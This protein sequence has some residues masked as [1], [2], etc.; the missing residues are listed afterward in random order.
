MQEVINNFWRHHITTSNTEFLKALAASATEMPAT[1]AERA[2]YAAAEQRAALVPATKIPKLNT[3]S[4]AFEPVM[5]KSA[6]FRAGTGARESFL[7]YK[8]IKTHGAHRVE[9]KGEE[10]RQDDLRVL[11]MLLKLNAGQQ[12]GEAKDFQEIGA[13]A[14][15][16]ELGKGWSDSGVSVA[17]LRGC[18]ARLQDARVRVHYAGGGLGMYSFISDAETVG[19]RWRVWLSVRHCEMFKRSVTYLPQADR[20]ALPDG[21]A[22]WL[23]GFI[24][25]DACY[26]GFKLCELRE[27]AGYTSYVQKD[28]NRTI[29]AALDV[30]KFSGL[31]DDYSIEDKKLTV[32]K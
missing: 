8:N 22:S 1:F 16:R 9:Y 14:F 4:L 27:L 23:L 29:R 31:I 3:N 24:K 28:F 13:R 20:L 30:L 32:R 7:E 19:E 10:L 21:L 2:F 6:L 17:K 11:L 15:C 18:I 25:A 5:L 12:L 26:V